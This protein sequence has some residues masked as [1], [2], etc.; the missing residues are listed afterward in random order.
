MKVA[1]TGGPSDL[2]QALAGE[3][4][5][6]HDV[7]IVDSDELDVLDAGSIA[8]LCDG[9][10][11]VVLL[12]TAPSD[13]QLDRA[14]KGAWNVMCAARDAGVSQV[15]QVSDVCIYD[16]YS[17][18]L[19]L[20][21]D[22]VPLPDTSVKQ[23]GLHLS[24]MI[25]HEFA[26][27]T[28]GFVLTL[29]LGRLVRSHELTPGCPFERDWLDLQDATGAIARG[30]ALDTY[31]HP[32]HWGVYNLVSDTPFRRFHLRIATGRFGYQPTQDFR[33]WW[34]EPDAVAS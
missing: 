15:V 6:D 23:Q 31:D 28:P 34:P 30:L 5:A 10:D 22:M 29:R 3:L 1:I 19:I 2:G 9:M 14:L 7:R 24:E 25:G 21:E 18:D 20:S 27:E 11:R 4:G 12:P 8:A 32:S 13:E 16:G 26:R 33:P 17:A